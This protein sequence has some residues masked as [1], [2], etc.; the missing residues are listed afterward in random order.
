[1]DGENNNYVTP[2][3]NEEKTVRMFDG[4]GL[5]QLPDDASTTYGRKVAHVLWSREELIGGVKSPGKDMMF[6]DSP[7][8]QMT[9]TQKA[10]F[11]EGDKSNFQM[12]FFE[13][14]DRDVTTN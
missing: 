12:F 13:V 11:H 7:R 10:V 9:P 6:L 14:N 1:M 8:T 2:V 5:Y 3:V 4:V